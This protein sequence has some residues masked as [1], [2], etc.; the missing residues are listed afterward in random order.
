MS[1]IAKN[2]QS[3]LETVKRYGSSSRY[4]GM[5]D[6]EDKYVKQERY[7]SEYTRFQEI[8]KAI[9]EQTPDLFRSWYYCYTDS[10]QYLSCQAFYTDPETGI[11]YQVWRKAPVYRYEK[12][13]YGVHVYKPATLDNKIEVMQRKAD[14]ITRDIHYRE[15]RMKR[16]KGRIIEDMKSEN[17]AQRIALENV[18][19]E[20]HS[21]QE[22][23]AKQA[24]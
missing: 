2:I 19:E 21:L 24:A 16:M 22:E 8:V 13:K 18:L 11:G 3:F 12:A 14:E 20:L 1:D 4:I 23:K 7:R 9:H 5:D 6:Y 10:R 17:A 15:E